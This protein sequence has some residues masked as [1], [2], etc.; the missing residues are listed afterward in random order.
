MPEKKVKLLSLLKARESKSQNNSFHNSLIRNL[1]NS[2]KKSLNERH[3]GIVTSVE[4]LKSAVKAAQWTEI[5]YAIEDIAS[6][7]LGPDDGDEQQLAVNNTRKEERSLFVTLEGAD[8]LMRLLK[9][10][11]VPPDGRDILPDLVQLRLS[12]WSGV[13]TILRELMFTMPTL[14]DNLIGDADITFLFTMLSHS[15]IFDVVMSLLEE[16]LASRLETYSLSLI[17]F[18]FSLIENFT[19][20]QLG[21]FCR[22]LSL[23]LFEPEDRQIMENT[24]TLRSLELLQMRR[25]RMARVQNVAENNQFFVSSKCFFIKI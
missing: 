20:R 9:E 18:A 15:S 1:P 12:T 23:V 17:P 16:I 2:C 8:T 6:K 10:P 11:L 25:D 4:S 14:A 13:F 5:E 24:H 22:V 19:T 3:N 21:H 7:L